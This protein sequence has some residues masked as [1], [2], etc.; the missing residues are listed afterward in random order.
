MQLE[1]S[2]FARTLRSQNCELLSLFVR[3]KLDLVVWLLELVPFVDWGYGHWIRAL[4]VGVTAT[5]LD[6]WI[7][8]VPSV[9]VKLI[10]HDYELFTWTLLM[11]SFMS[12]L[13]PPWV[14]PVYSD[15]ITDIYIYILGPSQS[16]FCEGCFQFCLPCPWAQWSSAQRF[17][18]GHVAGAVLPAWDWS[19]SI[20]PHQ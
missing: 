9:F 13:K 16:M 8:R 17:H 4:S 15:I 3:T 12:W 11:S 1:G 2:K 18:P 10:E 5:E 7:R 19:I 6:P 20:N 14:V